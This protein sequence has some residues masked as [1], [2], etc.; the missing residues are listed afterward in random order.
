MVSNK[1]KANV[2]NQIYLD[3][4]GPC[5]VFRN[6]QSIKGKRDI[7]IALVENRHNVCTKIMI[8]CKC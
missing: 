6:D 7:N 8:K 4:L 3:L 2:D 1:K 5:M